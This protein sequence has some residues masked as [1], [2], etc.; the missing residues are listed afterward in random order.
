LTFCRQVP[1]NYDR[2]IGCSND[3]AVDKRD[4]DDIVDLKDMVLAEMDARQL[5]LDYLN[6]PYHLYLEI[7]QSVDGK[8]HDTEESMGTSRAVVADEDIAGT[9]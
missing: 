8:I 1:D 2:K 6:R 9:R 3:L 4:D 7:S 5:S